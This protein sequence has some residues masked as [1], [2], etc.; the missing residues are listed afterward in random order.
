[1]YWYLKVIEHYTD[2]YG[3][4]RRKEYWMFFLFNIIFIVAA[5]I[6][7]NVSGLTFRHFHGYGWFY[8]M[9]S[10]IVFVPSLAVCVRRLHDT[11]RGGWNYLYS[12]IP[13]IGSIMLLIWMCEEGVTGEN[14]WGPDPKN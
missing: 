3:R 6:L 5:I 10:L 7:D 13:L 9:Y 12:L 4:A 1:M 8:L 11:G 2:F 14:E